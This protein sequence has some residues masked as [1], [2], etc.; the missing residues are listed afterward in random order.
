MSTPRSQLLFKIEDGKLTCLANFCLATHFPNQVNDQCYKLGDSGITLT[1]QN[2]NAV[3]DHPSGE[4]VEILE[5]D[6]VE[7]GN[8]IEFGR[9]I[10]LA[11]Y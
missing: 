10:E 7:K 11:V 5:R 8:E 6:S 1:L 3:L 2:N 9:F 4:N